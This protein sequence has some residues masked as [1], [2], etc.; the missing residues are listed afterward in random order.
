M[1]DMTLTSVDLPAP[2]SP[3]RPTT[4]SALT[5]KPTS[6]SAWTAPKRLLTPR[7]SSSG[8]V[9]VAV[10]LMPGIPSGRQP[11]RRAVALVRARAD[12][13]G[14]PE[15]VLDDG[16]LDVV[17]GD[18]DRLEDHRGDVLLAV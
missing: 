4:S 11:E 17:L 3:T 12:L 15:A 18:R 10:A 14:R 16:V 5:P 1:P 13:R 7:R 2:L 6:S 8:A 9:A